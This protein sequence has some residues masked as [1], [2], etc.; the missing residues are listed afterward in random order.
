MRPQLANTTLGAAKA[1]E[2]MHYPKKHKD[3]GRLRPF[4]VETKFDGERIQVGR[5][6]VPHCQGVA[7][8][9]CTAG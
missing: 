8:S 6:A 7:N 2:L 1:F 4:I 5:A 3:A 9:L